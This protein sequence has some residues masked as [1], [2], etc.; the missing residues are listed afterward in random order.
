[1][2]ISKRTIAE[3]IILGCLIISAVLFFRGRS[4][5]AV[6]PEKA[7]DLEYE[8]KIYPEY[9]GIVFPCNIAPMNFEIRE[10]GDSYIVRFSAENAEPII[11]SGKTV[12]IPEEKWKLFLDQAK[13]KKISVDIFAGQNNNWRHFKTIENTVSPDPIDGW[14]MYRLI[15]PGYEFFSRITLNQRNTESFKAEAF[16]QNDNMNDRV[17]MNCHSFQ[18]RKTDR[19]LFHVRNFNPGTVLVENGSVRKID[20]KP[21]GLFSNCTYPAW[22]PS[23]N[24]VAFS[25]NNTFQAFHTSLNNR[26]E[27]MDNYS[28]LAVFYPDSNEVVHVLDTKNDYETFPSW[29]PDGKYLYFCSAKF[30]PENKILFK[31]DADKVDEVSEK[32]KAE[33]QKR[34]QEF[35]YSLMRMSYDSQKKKFGVPEM[36]VDSSQT[37][38]SIVHPRVSPDGRWLMFTMS[39]YGTFPIW[40]RDSDLFLLDLQS[41]QFRKMDEINSD[42]SESYHTWDSS[43]KWFVFSSRREDGNFTRLYFAHFQDGKADKPFLLPQRDPAQNGSLIKSYNVPEL[44]REPVR[45]SI[46]KLTEAAQSVSPEPTVLRSVEK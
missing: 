26:I 9:S 33:F 29:S 40:H 34:Y 7:E 12:Q 45:T 44:V 36:V 43:G 27:V 15:E 8:A 18:D 31:D 37:G 20:L 39:A 19:F 17:C 3:I 32:S 23:E 38:K 42:K 4:S 24:L 11:L 30:K 35:K 46:R 5:G 16:V 6:V 10:E 22:H 1:M 25:V 2:K 14:L 41:G 13:G 21:E 28:D